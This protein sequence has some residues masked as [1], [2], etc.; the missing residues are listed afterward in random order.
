MSKLSQAKKIIKLLEENPN[1]R[2][3][4]RDIAEKIVSIY[5]QDYEDKK[6]NPRFKDEKSFI[7][8]I[9]AEIGAQKDQLI[10]SN[11]HIFWQD[12]PRPRVY[13][14]DPDKKR[15]DVSY[16]DIENDDEEKN[17]NIPITSI[18]NSSSLSEHDL[19]PL[20]IDYLNSEHKL[21]CMRIDEKKSKNQRGL[22]GNTWLHP[23]IVAMQAVDK[24]WNELV[25]TCVKNGD[26]QSV[27]LWSF[28][29]KITLNSSNVRKS[30]FQAVSN[31]SWANEGYLVATSISDNKVEQELRMLS[32]LHGIGVIL[33]NPEN[34]SESEILL[35]A[36]S[37]PEI[38]WQ[39]VNRILVENSDFKDY[40]EL[41]S[42]YYQT[43]RIRKKDWNK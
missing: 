6:N 5:P 3:S 22:G 21:F 24:E 19:Y 7:S 29:V 41:V 18:P 35:P 20:L 31:S 38:D 11:E 1:E 10:K 12:K 25:R 17:K 16:I 9:V 13:W 4:A 2:F 8:Q 42:T 23:D 36:K 33:L 43:G 27:R 39:S 40:I 34:P 30:F 32:A 14:Y 28:E 37:R 26:G 15:E